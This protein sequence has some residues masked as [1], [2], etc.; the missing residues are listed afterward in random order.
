MYVIRLYY[1]DFS[2]LAY[3]SAG[4][5]KFFSQKEAEEA[6]IFYP[7]KADKQVELY[8]GINKKDIEYV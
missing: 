5:L 4:M 1:S 3:N 6:C 8:D 7:S 2:C